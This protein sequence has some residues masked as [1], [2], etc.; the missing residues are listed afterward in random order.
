MSVWQQLNHDSI[1]N[2]VEKTLGEKM[3]NLLLKRNSY[4]NRVYELEKYD[5][6][7]RVIVKF[8][9]PE[10]WTKDQIKE[11]HDFLFELAKE[12]IKVIPPLL[13]NNQSL[14]DLSPINYTLFPKKGGRALDEFNQESWEELGRLLARIHLIGA[15]HKESSRITWRPS[16]ATKH[17]LEVLYKTDYLDQKFEPSFKKVAELFMG[18]A[19][20]MFSD[21][22]FILLHGDCHKGNL[23]HRP[24]EGIYI[25]DFDDISFGPPVQDLW[26]LLPGT[27]ENCENEL[28]WFLKGYEVFRKFDRKSLEL[29]PIL[30]GMRIIH[31]VSWLA[32]QSKDPDFITHFPHAGTSRYWNELIKDLQS[33][34]Y[35]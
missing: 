19:E 12:E 33:I 26:L 14:F 34:C 21:Q 31:Y 32:I 25:V 30:R 23:I 13:I 7:E 24:N 27:P 18:K 29:I 35:N 8:Y 16:I 20:P 1:L 3:S 6:R 15:K 10:R 11:E 5:S 4:I 9:R 2:A 17:H 28:E 22:E